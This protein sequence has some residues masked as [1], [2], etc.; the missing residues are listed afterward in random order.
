[1]HL[2]KQFGLPSRVRMD[3][4]G[5]NIEI[6]RYMLNH[7]DRGPGRGSAITGRSTHNHRIERLWRDLYSG[8]VSFFYLLFYSME[9]IQLLNVDDT[10]DIYTLHFVFVSII[11]K[12]LNL[13]RQGWAHHSLRTEHNKS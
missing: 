8:C 10:R 12:H 4:G 9:D 2:L 3:R 13:F 6:V 1:M 11:Q 7:V 5:E